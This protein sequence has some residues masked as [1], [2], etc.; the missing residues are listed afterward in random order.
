[1]RDEIRN[2][3]FGTLAFSPDG[4]L[5][6]Y[7]HGIRWPGAAGDVDI[8]LCKAETGEV[9]RKLQGHKGKVWSLAFSPDGE[10]ASKAIKIRVVRPEEKRPEKPEPAQ[11]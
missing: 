11:C 1:V 8:R 7:E 9:V 2:V 5:L 6:A 4:K 3:V 10:R